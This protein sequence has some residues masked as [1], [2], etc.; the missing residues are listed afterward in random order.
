MK[1]ITSDLKNLEVKSLHKVEVSLHV[2]I[3][4]SEDK[5][6]TLGNISTAIKAVDAGTNKTFKPIYDII[7]FEGKKVYQE[8][9]S[10]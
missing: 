2:N 5:K 10:T 7:D 4:I 6:V 9:I 1:E 8:D 3:E